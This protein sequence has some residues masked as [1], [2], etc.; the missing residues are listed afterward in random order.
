MY[1]VGIIIV[2]ASHTARGGVSLFYEWFDPH[3][4]IVPH[5]LFCSGYFFK[6]SSV[7][8]AGRYILKKARHLLIPL[9]GWNLF[10]ALVVFV[11]SKAG[12]TIGTPVTIGS[13]LWSPLFDG[14]QFGY[15]CSCWFLAPLFLIEVINVLLR[16]AVR[17]WNKAPVLKE[18]VIFAFYLGLSFLGIF[19]AKKYFVNSFFWW[20]LLMRVMFFISAYGFGTFFNRVL[21]KYDRRI[22]SWLYFL[23]V[24]GIEVIIILALGRVPVYDLA[25]G[26]KYTDGVILPVLVG[27]LGVLFWLRI[28]RIVE[29]VTK[30]NRIVNALSSGTMYIMVHH[31]LGTML[32]KGIIA[33]IA[34]ATPLFGDFDFGAFKTELFY[35][36]LP[37]GMDQF[38]IVYLLAGLTVPLL[39]RMLA[40][41]IRIFRK[42]H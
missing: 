1:A 5:F 35:Y 24:A 26:A 42:N 33:V 14:F 3:T 7:E 16:K 32:V 30:N 29:P 8:H 23:V 22:S 39:I 34:K 40:D 20:N 2:V 10:Y 12:F 25:W 41:R 27:F 4:F 6:D 18:S 19:L 28:A 38:R 21:E 36:Y 11:T 37:N 9:Y 15:N 13:L 17:N 31:F